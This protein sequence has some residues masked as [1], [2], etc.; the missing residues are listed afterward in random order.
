MKLFNLEEAKAGAKL[1]TREGRP[2]FVLKYDLRGGYPLLGYVA[3]E[4]EDETVIWTVGGQVYN[5]VTSENDL[6]LYEPSEIKVGDTCKTTK[7]HP[8]RI[9]C[10][11]RVHM[12]PVVGLAADPR[13]VEYTYG[14]DKDGVALEGGVSLDLTTLNHNP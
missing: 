8:V 3:Y 9:I 10:V 5:E 14:W 13:G 7:G 11:D 1:V 4:E 12:Y 2:A 6:F